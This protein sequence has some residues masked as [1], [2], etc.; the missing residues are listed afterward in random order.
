M[1]FST[2]TRGYVMGRY[3][4]RRAAIRDTVTPRASLHNSGAHESFDDMVMM[5][6]WCFKSIVSSKTLWRVM[7]IMGGFSTMTK[8]R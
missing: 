6:V 5:T 7:E 8:M 1:R 3:V 2:Q 4:A